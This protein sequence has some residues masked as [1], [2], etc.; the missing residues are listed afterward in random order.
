MRDSTSNQTV[1]AI[2]QNY[3]LTPTFIESLGKVTKVYTNQGVYAL[4][5]IDANQGIDFIRYVQSLYQSG[6]NR[7]VPIYPTLDGRYGILYNHQLYY[8]MPWLANAEKGDHSKLFRELARLH[9]LSAREVKVNKEHRKAHFD[10]S[11][12]EL[13]REEALINELLGEYERKIYM[14]PFELLFCTYYPT[15]KHALTFSKR[16]LNEWY[17]ATKEKDKARIVIIH[18]KLS[19]DHFLFDE[20]GYGYFSNFEKT[21]IG[22]PIHDLLPFMVKT[23]RGFPKESEELVEWLYTYFKYFPFQDEEMGLFLSYL[24]QP[25]FIIKTSERLF[26]EG[27]KRQRH[28]RRAVKKLQREFWLLKNIEYVVSRIDEIERHKK[29]QQQQEQQ[30]EEARN[31]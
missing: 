20:K 18:G 1:T 26:R 30:Q 8:L 15:I 27:N 17:E 13:E 10:K 29:I 19:N 9:T 12:E 25:S 7:I 5:K 3:G 24:A 16:K 4:K 31:D 21:S 14:S 22:S 2:L 6:Y 28:E 23:L 11:I